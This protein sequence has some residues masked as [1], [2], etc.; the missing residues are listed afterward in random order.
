MLLLFFQRISR[1]R[2]GPHRRQKLLV[3]G[4]GHVPASLNLGQALAQLPFA[5]RCSSHH[6]LL[7][8]CQLPRSGL[9]HRHG[10]NHYK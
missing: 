9:A 4:H 7:D 3:R 10:D 8:P 5:N 2:I 6:N 1:H